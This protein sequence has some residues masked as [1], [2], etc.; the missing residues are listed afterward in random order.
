[1]CVCNFFLFFDV[2]RRQKIRINSRIYTSGLYIIRV[3]LL[4]LQTVTARY[5]ASDIHGETRFFF[6]L[7]CGSSR[8]LF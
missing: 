3:L 2:V 1:M 6:F 5:T 4:L 7:I 8:I